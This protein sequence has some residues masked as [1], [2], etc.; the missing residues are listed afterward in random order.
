MYYT[1][2]DN[3]KITLIKSN[4]INHDAAQAF[5]R[6]SITIRYPNENIIDD[7]PKLLDA[8]NL[9]IESIKL[10][11]LER[12]QWDEVW[13]IF[14]IID[15]GYFNNSIYFLIGFVDSHNSLGGIFYALN[16]AGDILIEKTLVNDITKPTFSI[17]FSKI[18][19]PDKLIIFLPEGN[20]STRISIIPIESAN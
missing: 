8:I 11:L 1:I 15:Y 9:Q 20:L 5:Y 4:L 13:V 16:S 12:Y 19:S 10:I 6:N 7:Y 17:D 18:L 3:N 14:K 2:I